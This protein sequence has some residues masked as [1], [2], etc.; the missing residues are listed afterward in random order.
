MC[1]SMT[2]TTERGPEKGSLE[3]LSMTSL[4]CSIPVDLA[5]LPNSPR[6]RKSSRLDS[7]I[8]GMFF[9]LSAEGTG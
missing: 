3:I 4:I 5:R 9:S 8:T 1:A 7:M 6:A 2:I